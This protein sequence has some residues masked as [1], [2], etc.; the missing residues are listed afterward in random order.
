MTSVFD[1]LPGVEIPPGEIAKKL[2]H[3]WS[4]AE[5]QSA[6]SG[7]SPEGGQNAADGGSA[8]AAAASSSGA[9]DATATQVN[10]VLHL[11]LPTTPADAVEQFQTLLRFSK[12]YPSRMVI[13]CPQS[14][15]EDK[16]GMEIR[17]KIYGE[18]HYGK[19]H[20][21][22]RCVEVVVL[23]YSR[24][25]R[26]FLENQVSISLSTDLPL[27]YWAHRFSASSRLA[28]Y[29]FLLSRAERVLIDSA[30]APE[31]A[32]TYPWPRLE[33]LRDLAYARLLPVRQTV[34]QFLAGYAPEL[35]VAGLQ[36]V[37]V[38]HSASLAGEARVISQWLRERVEHCQA[39]GQGGSSRQSGDSAPDS[40]TQP[41]A[42]SLGAES[43][44]SGQGLPSPR[45]IL[46]RDASGESDGIT[47]EFQYAQPEKY[48]RW[49]G[50]FGRSHACFAARLD[51]AQAQL[52]APLK[53]LPPELALS[54]AMF[55]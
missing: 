52:D 30:T 10:F 42:K 21:D 4:A 32:L 27:Y 5:A 1:A 3:M 8:Q 17:A 39:A 2:A 46:E 20:S 36:T 50:D 37:R 24:A 18:C 51:D 16:G 15:A 22:K 33:A 35:I 25:A 13:L 26:G 38:R 28:D 54:E 12:R 49:T 9:D 6:D 34:G 55:F 53:P 23:D 40:D 29:R 41:A 45:Y 43:N 19:S 11:G 48:F 7:A 14:D 31:D 44:S 47:I